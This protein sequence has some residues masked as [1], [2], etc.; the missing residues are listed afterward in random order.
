MGQTDEIALRMV[1]ITKRFPGVLAND[2]ITLEV[3]AGEVHG[4]L[5][6]NGAGKTTLMN[7]LYGLHQPD[8]GRIS[9]HDKEVSITSPRVA[10]DGATRSETSPFQFMSA[11]ALAAPIDRMSSDKRPSSLARC[12]NP[13]AAARASPHTSS[14]SEVGCDTVKIRDGTWPSAA[15]A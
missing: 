7:I 1:G 2:N 6:E 9:I 3:R 13:R 11:L 12:Q 5:G 15:G 4:L 8:S 14:V 10:L